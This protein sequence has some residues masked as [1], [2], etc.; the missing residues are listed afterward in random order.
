[1]YN[2]NFTAIF[3]IFISFF[4][5]SCSTDEPDNIESQKEKRNIKQISI[6]LP[7]M[8]VLTRT[9]LDLSEGNAKTRWDK[10]DIVGVVNNSN[11]LTSIPIIHEGDNSVQLNGED[12]NMDI[13]HSYAAYY[14]YIN[15]QRGSIP[16]SYNRQ[17][18]TGNENS[19]HIARYD[20]MATGQ[21]NSDSFN[22][23]EF[24]LQRLG[25]IIVL[26]IK[27]PS[28]G[29]YTT[30]IL[31][32]EEPE[33][34]T[35]A[36]LDI[37]QDTPRIQPIETSNSYYII[38][39][40]VRLTEYDQ[41]LTAY[42]T[43]LPIDLTK[44]KLKITL[45]GPGN[46]FSSELQPFII[47]AGKVYK[48]TV[49]FENI[50]ISDPWVKQICLSKWDFDGNGELSY[51]EAKSISDIGLTFNNSLIKS[52]DEFE[53]FQ[54]ITEIP[55]SAFYSCSQLTKIRFP[56]GIKAIGKNAF[57]KTRISDISLPSELKV[58]GE[59][60]FAESSLSK[61]TL[62]D[63]LLSIKKEAFYHCSLTSIT[64]PKSIKSIEQYAFAYCYRLA[65]I[66]CLAI[67]P[68]EITSLSFYGT[69]DCPIYV[70][71]EAL[72]DYKTKWPYYAKRIYAIQEN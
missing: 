5:Y 15:N 23:I 25:A 54:G 19:S 55:D 31:D 38:L 61:I 24:N 62:P 60:G 40:D 36:N 65:K 27:V 20:Y 1:M 6:N 72:S 42:F 29:I 30:L 64:I 4:I 52:F 63:S 18:Q 16:L 50:L 49:S 51:V 21:V 13:N 69:N 67:T 58:I 33:F 70:P 32:S 57:K 8:E 17:V 56:N 43:C 66:T 47:E 9:N 68:P 26:A 10:G 53:F 22:N 7:Q 14:P 39:D 3:S 46:Y 48:L 45:M 34:I 41:F 37:S 59:R 11:K 2:W 28:P 44:G 12:L 71:S 35:N